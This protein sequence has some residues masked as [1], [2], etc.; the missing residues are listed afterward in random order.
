MR[1]EVDPTCLGFVSDGPVPPGATARVT[2]YPQAMFKARRLFVTE[3]SR[4]FSIA[5]FKIGCHS[6]FPV[7]IV[8]IPAECFTRCHGG[9]LLQ[10]VHRCCPLRPP[11]LD[12]GGGEQWEIPEALADEV[13]RI[14]EGLSCDTAQVA[15]DM[16][17][18]VRNDGPESR[19]FRAALFGA[20]LE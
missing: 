20:A 9:K 6:Q 19:F 13:N 16:T 12:V 2:S 4:D 3:G 7:G 11:H 17:F 1:R 18:I 14:G 8:P 10:F 15:M 5:D